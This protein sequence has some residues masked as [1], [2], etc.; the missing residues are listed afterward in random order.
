MR[1]HLKSNTGLIA[2]AIAF[3]AAANG[4]NIITDTVHS[5]NFRWIANPR[6]PKQIKAR[7]KVKQQRKCRKLSRPSY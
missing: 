6:T 4:Q 2:G 7:S 5:S 3:A 1:K